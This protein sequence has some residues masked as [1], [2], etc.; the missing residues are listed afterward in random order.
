MK[1]IQNGSIIFIIPIVLIIIG[2]ILVSYWYQSN[3]SNKSNKKNSQE[4]QI[5]LDLPR[6]GTSSAKDTLYQWSNF[7]VSF[8]KPIG[9]NINEK[10]NSLEVKKEEQQIEISTVSTNYQTLEEYITDISTKNNLKYIKKDKLIFNGKEVIKTLR[11]TADQKEE[12]TYWIYHDYG[13]YFVSTTDK[14]LYETTEQVARS[15]QFK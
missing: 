15:I 8:K 11:K 13:M 1:P 10:S 7:G 3:Q 2:I 5:T 9:F 12:L 4:T 14:D 6:E